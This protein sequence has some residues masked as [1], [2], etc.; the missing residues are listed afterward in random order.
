M[1]PAHSLSVCTQLNSGPPPFHA[2][3]LQTQDYKKD[4]YVFLIVSNWLVSAIHK[5]HIMYMVDKQCKQFLLFY[6][7]L[8]PS[9]NFFALS[10]SKWSFGDLTT[11]KWIVNPLNNVGSTWNYHIWCAMVSSTTCT[12]Y[13]GNVL[14]EKKYIIQFTKCCFLLY[15]ALIFSFFLLV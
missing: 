12:K 3:S 8:L 14:T 4:N 7:I 5:L 13:T 11:A 9:L 15:L 6:W 10:T 1:L 2:N